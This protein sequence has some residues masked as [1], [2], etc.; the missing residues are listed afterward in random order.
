MA[1]AFCIIG[2]QRLVERVEERRVFVA[3]NLRNGDKGEEEEAGEND[4]IVELLGGYAVC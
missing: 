1:F 4:T 2:Q 3:C